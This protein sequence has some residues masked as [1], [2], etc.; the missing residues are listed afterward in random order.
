MRK[1]FLLSR[2]DF[3]R[4]SVFIYLF[5]VRRTYS[6]NRP[7][8]S[9]GQESSETNSANIFMSH[10]FCVSRTP[11]SLART[12]P[13]LESTGHPL[14]ITK[15]Q[16]LI[17]RRLDTAITLAVTAAVVAIAR[18]ARSAGTSNSGI[19]EAAIISR[20]VVAASMFPGKW[21]YWRIRSVWSSLRIGIEYRTE[22]RTR[23]RPGQA[24]VGHGEAQQGA[25]SRLSDYKMQ[26]E[27]KR[28]AKTDMASEHAFA[29]IDPKATWTYSVIG[30]PITERQQQSWQRRQT[31]KG[32]EIH[33]HRH[34]PP[35]EGTIGE[36][37]ISKRKELG[38]QE[39][40]LSHYCA[41]GRISSTSGSRGFSRRH[42]GG[43]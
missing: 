16:K 2:N 15:R 10:H 12:L 42:F 11:L 5:T 40:V 43:T 26:R 21:P 28:E 8:F 18:G 23:C 6:T 37:T 24:I 25:T 27:E 32:T 13:V 3:G 38:R 33:R 14:V 22:D 35:T 4:Y 17:V 9:W 34:L 7:I 36:G 20:A 31:K 39:Q 1:Y 41:A 29:R 19:H 30:V